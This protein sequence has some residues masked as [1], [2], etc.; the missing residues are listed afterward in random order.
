MDTFQ[1]DVDQAASKTENRKKAR[2]SV[3]CTECVM[4]LDE[5]NMVMVVQIYA[6]CLCYNSLENDACFKSGQKWLEN[7]HLALII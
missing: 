7:N 2:L 1:W 6:Q 3:S 4:D 5:L